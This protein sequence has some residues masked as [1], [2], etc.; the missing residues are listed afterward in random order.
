MEVVNRVLCLDVCIIQ[1]L[2]GFGFTV[3]TTVLSDIEIIESAIR[4]I[5]FVLGKVA[6][7]N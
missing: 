1:L 2:V 7:R 5:G 4:L 3:N 6:W